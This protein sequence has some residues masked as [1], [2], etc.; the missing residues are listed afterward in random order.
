MN[1]QLRS[2]TGNIPSTGKDFITYITSFPGDNLKLSLSNVSNRTHP[3]EPKKDSSQALI[4]PFLMEIDF[5]VP[6][7]AELR[8]NFS[9]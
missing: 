2:C 3:G 9:S 7:L 5:P 6:F 8:I 4:D 1:E